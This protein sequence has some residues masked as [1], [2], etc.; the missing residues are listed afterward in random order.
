[1]CEWLKIHLPA[2]SKA[3]THALFS[4]R[5]KLVMQRWKNFA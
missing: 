1:M 2:T 5:E 3:F 4:K